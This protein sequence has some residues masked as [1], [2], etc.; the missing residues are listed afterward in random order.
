ML[1]LI[2]STCL[3]YGLWLIPSK[4]FRFASYLGYLAWILH[5]II[6]Y[7][8]IFDANG[9]KLNIANSVLL[10]SWLSVMIVFWYKLT[11]LWVKIPLVFFVCLS[12]IIIYFNFSS[13]PI[14]YKMFSWQLDLHI[15]LSMLA[16]SIFVVAT[17]FAISLYSHIKTIKNKPFSVGSSLVS[18]VDEEQKLF[19]LIF[20]G[21]LVL[22]T[23]LFSGVVFVEDFMQQH[24]GH[25]VFF[26][27]LAWLVFGGI[28]FARLTR[29]MRGEKLI[30]TTIFGMFFL[31]TGYLGSKIV[32]ELL[33]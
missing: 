3:L 13:H 5:G 18:I 12:L 22:T 20:L 17:L 11:S 30:V 25:K 31:A 8:S 4:S 10:V 2:I 28:I 23:S 6:C 7:N 33:L 24:L 27:I 29:G 15:S 26:S 21:W 1:A 32:L 19:K 16:Y 14:D 9:W